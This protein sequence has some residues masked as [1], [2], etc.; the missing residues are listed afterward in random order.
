MTPNPSSHEADF[1]DELLSKADALIKRN[2]PDG[3]NSESEELPMLTEV[4]DNLP[5]LTEIMEMPKVMALEEEEI[6]PVGAGLTQDQ[7]NILIS[8][9]IERTQRDLLKNQDRV[10]QETVDRTRAENIVAHTQAA[11]AALAQGR[12][13][14]REEGL[15][16][17][18]SQGRMEGRNESHTQHQ[19]AIESMRREIHH[20]VVLQFSEQ[21]IELDAYISQSIDAWLTRE[22]PQIIASQL[23]EVGERIRS[24]TAAHMR[25][26]LLP[27]L[28]NKLSALLDTKPQ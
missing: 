19:L 8:D 12:R 11:Q 17:G 15:A 23:D 14:G 5:E 24:H 7:V 1:S 25:A 28:S 9:A 13:E 18:I 4:V 10:I 22:L 6:M 3:V 20:N 21:L 16:Q 2:R 26:T 27:E